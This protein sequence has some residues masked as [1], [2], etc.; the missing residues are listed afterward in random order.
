MD[1]SH[2]HRF[3]QRVSHELLANIL[4]FWQQYA[5][6]CDGEG[7]YAR[8]SNDLKVKE[9]SP[10]GLILNTRILW[11]FS[12][13]YRQFQKEEYLEIADRAFRVIQ[14]YFWDAAYG[15]MYWL[16]DAEHH[17]LDVSKKIYGQAFSIY[18]L[19]EYYAAARDKAALQ[20]AQ[21]LYHLIEENN[22]DAA[23]DGYFETSNRDWTPA[24]DLRLSEI[25]LNE[26]KSMNTHLHMLEA[27]THLYR[28]WPSPQLKQQLR[29]LIDCFLDH[30][31]DSEGRHFQLFFDE[32]WQVKSGSVS[33]GHD[34]EGS[35]LLQ[36]AAQV[37]GDHELAKKVPPISLRMAEAVL[38][39]AVS[40]A[41]GIFYERDEGGRLDEE[42]HWWPQAEAVVGFL[43]AFQRSNDG[44][45]WDAACNVWRFC[46]NY[47]VDRRH[48]E[49]FY[50][51]GI[52]LKPD[53]TMFKVSEWKCPYHSGRA[54]LE[55]IKRIDEIITIGKK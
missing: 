20:R 18:S 4:P 11:T 5:V 38:T 6:D 19:V 13:A 44:R 9:R 12:A 26:K 23:H 51:V 24:D 22:F 28:F 52:D 47:L 30:I 36:E 40:K 16:L 3:Q 54:C 43:N 21:E 32:Q 25:D 17:P 48:G 37:Y 27:Y 29:R 49:W 1:H 33:F 15:G 31:V 2:L 55:V 35:W 8:I 53:L 46:E 7:F 45:F 39:E 42:M 14:K 10:R 34:I 41:G 50:K